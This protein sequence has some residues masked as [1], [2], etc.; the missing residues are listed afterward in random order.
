MKKK[1]IKSPN[2]IKLFILVNIIVLFF[3]ALTFGREYVGNAQI[4]RE[5]AQM[6]QERERLEQDRLDTLNLIDQ[7][8]S[9][10]Y[11]EKEGRLKYGLAKEG[12]TLIVVKEPELGDDEV[13]KD[14][15]VVDGL[16][17]NPKRWF[18]YFFDKAKYDGERIL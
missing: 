8:S 6:E 18:Y 13:A 2:K 17:S 15:N 9:E 11:L 16:H 7:L 1:L 12:E 3:L 14:K 10:D 5:I 4:E